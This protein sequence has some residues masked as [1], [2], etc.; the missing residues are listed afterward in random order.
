MKLPPDSDY[1]LA[2]DLVD[3]P[4]WLAN[5]DLHWII[6]IAGKPRR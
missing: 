2:S 1:R 6:G 5:V 3:L 4:G